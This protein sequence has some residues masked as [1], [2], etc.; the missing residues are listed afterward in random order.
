M[1]TFRSTPQTLSLTSATAS[2]RAA[3]VPPPDLVSARHAYER[4]SKGPAQ[5]LNPA[6]LD[7]AKKQLDVAEAWFSRDGDTQETRDQSY[8]ALRWA[9]V[10]EVVGLALLANGPRTRR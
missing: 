8:L 2:G 10:S 1:N 4:A 7:A 6:G 9:E 5:E 3:S